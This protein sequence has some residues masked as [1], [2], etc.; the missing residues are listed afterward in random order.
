MGQR[1]LADQRDKIKARR[2]N[3]SLWKQ[4]SLSPYRQ[5]PN[6]QG[7]SQPPMAASGTAR[8]ATALAIRHVIVVFNVF[9]TGPGMALTSTVGLGSGALESAPLVPSSPSAP[10]PAEHRPQTRRWAQSPAPAPA[11]APRRGE[12]CANPFNS[13]QEHFSDP[14]PG[15][16]LRLSHY[17]GR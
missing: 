8:P 3:S 10:D 11:A 9:A 17:P 13:P 7:R 6:Y 12:V 16:P 4:E 5:T 14:E 1:G 15:S 2:Q